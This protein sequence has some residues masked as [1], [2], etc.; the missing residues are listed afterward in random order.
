[1]LSESQFA[2]SAVDRYADRVQPD[3]DRRAGAPRRRLYRLAPALPVSR[4]AADGRLRQD[5]DDPRPRQ[6]ERAELHGEAHGLSRLCRGRAA[7]EHRG[8]R[9]SRTSRR[10]TARS[11]ARCRPTCT[12]RWAASA[13]SP[14]ARSATFR[15]SPK[16]FRCWPARS[17]RRT[18]MCTWPI[19]AFRSPSTAWTVKSGDLIHA[20]RHGAVIVPVDKI[21]AMKAAL[22]GLTKQEARIIAAARA[23]GAS[24]ESIKAAFRG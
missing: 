6:G 10:A 4:S 3:R 2:V 24:V 5:G 7:A 20:D 19:S 21:D 17:R 22:D 18:P 14:T 12:R 16:A 1:M 23:P 8:D 9:G 15:R 11:G 13:P